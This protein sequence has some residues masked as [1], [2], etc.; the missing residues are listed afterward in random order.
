MQVSPATLLLTGSQERAVR[1]GDRDLWL[2]AGAGSGK[3]RV[4]TERYLHLLTERS[5]PMQQILAITFTEKAA[6]E[7]R[8][9]IAGRLRE[10]GRIDSLH[11]LPHAPIGTIDSFCYRLV[12]EYAD[13]AGVDPSLRVIEPVEAAEWQE[14][15]WIELLDRWWERRKSDSVELFG[16]LPWNVGDRHAGGID[17]EP[18]FSLI[19]QV[20]TAGRDPLAISFEADCGALLEE[21]WS[22]VPSVLEEVRNLPAAKLPVKTA[23]KLNDLLRL[24]GT[25]RLTDDE[26]FELARSVRGNINRNVSAGARAVMARAIALLEEVESIERERS[27]KRPRLLLGDLARDFH[28]EYSARKESA[29]VADFLD[30]EET[31]ARLLQDEQVRGEIR[32]RHRYLLLDECQDTNELQLGIVKN[33]RNAGCFLAVGDAK[34][35]IYRFR[36]ADVTAFVEMGNGL[37]DETS[38]GELN[39]NFRSREP[40]LQWIN[41]FFPGIWSSNE[42]MGVPYE[43]L[44]AANLTFSGKEEP[45]IEFLRVVGESAEEAR[46]GEAA[47]L[48]ERLRQIGEEQIDGIRYGEMAVLF[49]SASGMGIFERELRRRGV[50][51]VV[52]VGRGF[53]QTREVADLLLGLQ[54]VDDARDDL[55]LA[56]ALRSP[57]AGLGHDDLVRLLVD[58]DRSRPLWEIL[59]D[60]RE[61]SSLSK[62][63]R[64]IVGRFVVSI[65]KF[66]SLRGILPAYRILES[67]LEETGYLD[68]VLLIPGG[69]R[70]RA[71]CLKLIEI[72]RELDGR[73][74]QTLPEAVRS[75][76][77]YRYT[78]LREPESA[79][80]EERNAVRLMT[81]HGAKGMEF[82][83]V[84]VADIG[85][86][87]Q[88]SHPPFLYRRGEGVGARGKDGAR[89][90]NKKPFVYQSSVDLEN[91]EEEAEEVRLFY[92]AA[93]RAERHL[94]LSGS[95]ARR[96]SGWLARL[97]NTQIEYDS[98]GV[99]ESFGVPVRI[100]PT[101]PDAGAA[102]ERPLA[103]D[104]LLADPA[105]FRKSID[106]REIRDAASTIT[107]PRPT[108]GPPASG[109]TVTAV[110]RFAL[111]PLQYRYSRTTPPRRPPGPRSAGPRSDDPRSTTDL[112]PGGSDLGTQLHHAMEMGVLHL[113]AGL[114]LSTCHPEEVLGWRDRLLDN[115]FMVDL[116]KGDEVITEQSFAVRLNGVL[117]RG[118][119]DLLVRQG[120]LW[121]IVDY[122]TDQADPAEIVNRHTLSITLYRLAVGEIVGAGVKV[123]A[124][125]AVGSAAAVRGYVGAVREGTLVPVSEEAGRSALEMLS[126]FDRAA[127]SGDY[128]AEPSSACVHCDWASTC[129]AASFAP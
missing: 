127:V 123:S 1:A 76:G 16:G 35:S 38:R 20:R 44:E 124:D 59:R 75:L 91:R 101:S 17:P 100:L 110:H 88:R 121:H 10:T 60:E 97:E 87:P 116:L 99:T 92:V 29:A 64:E 74:E 23:K 34:Q 53:F 78:R 85:R 125:D 126:R 113:S 84:A 43:P 114:P 51:V 72:A 57:L 73:G 30:V 117:L 65:G 70:K 8:D 25:G 39:E 11:E 45:S 122:K 82:P 119:I 2:T 52:A 105:R 112:L 102:I 61:T 5:I 89:G 94:I 83:L 9:R 24:D 41:R 128:P 63:G 14:R 13:R 107:A 6:S 31:A 28:R 33:L 27:I 40:I 69:R 118:K 98:P 67:L 79:V 48:A 93:T 106:S 4:L 115:P 120:N 32:R 3:T 111:C 49:R 129:P 37:G 46:E 15:V 54:L 68:S 58:R 50:P 21:R 55:R 26:K 36:D 47:I 56:A 22:L 71:N 96:S 66:R 80:D 95:R 18:L 103:I 104:E 19:R 81:I 62:E 42:G 7:M 77:R 86:Q 12:R 108:A 109:R 90:K